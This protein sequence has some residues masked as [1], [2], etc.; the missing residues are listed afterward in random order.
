MTTQTTAAFYT[1][2]GSLDKIQVGP[3]DL[4]AVGECD[5]LLRVKA[6]GLNPI[7]YIV[8]EGYYQQALP[9]VFPTVPGFD[10]AGIVEQVGPGVSRL[11][12]GDEVF[13]MVYRPVAQHGTLAERIVVPESYLTLRPHTLSWEAAAGLPLASI[14]AYQA[15][16]TAGQLQ[17][18]ETVLIL[19]G[20]GGVG[21]TAIQL[22][23]HAG[24]TVIA[25]ASAKNAA[26][27]QSLGA[28][29]TVDYAAGPIAEAVQQVAPGG[30][31]LLF[32]TVSGDTLL[33]SLAALKP[34][35]RLLSLLNDGTA[36]EL[37]A[38]VQFKHVIAHL[39]LPDLEHLRELADAG[40][41]QIPLA[42][43]FPLTGIMQAFRQLE[44]QRTVGKL[45]IVP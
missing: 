42:G 37:P 34:A 2:F 12:V 22:A 23:K 44:S 10:V 14:T 17:A 13:G 9:S 7:D 21:S 29:F 40:H 5:V 18:G 28:D 35:G 38:G 15:V 24:A 41:L 43:T 11:R 26:Y 20:S 16:I 8:R 33:Q 32:D 27:M 25:V 30:I 4:P 39:S 45:V 19:G 1:E 3:L 31:D 6:A 36:L